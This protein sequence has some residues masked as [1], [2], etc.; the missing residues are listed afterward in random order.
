MSNHLVNETSPYLLQHADNPVEWY[1]WGEEAFSK[2]RAEDKPIFLSIGYSACHWCHVMAH[3]SF[4]DTETA[5][6]LN[7]SFIS[8]KVDREERPDIDNVYMAAC[9]A[10]TGSGGWPLT[11]FLTPEKKPF[12]AGTYFPKTAQ[13]G[14]LGFRELLNAINEAWMHDREHLI[15]SAEALTN[16]FSEKHE[17]V[18]GADNLV[19]R[20]LSALLKSFD[21]TCGGFGRAPKFPMPQHLLFLLQQ[22]EKNNDAYALYAATFTLER[23]YAGGMFDH[24][25]GGFCR[26]STDRRFLVPHFEKMLYD[27]ALLI[28]VY[29]K[30]FE[31]TGDSLF[32]D[33]AERTADY[34]LS[35]M[36]S[37]NGGFFSA[38]DADSEGEEGRFYVFTPEEIVSVL[39]KEAGAAFNAC[40]DITA[41]GNF[42]GRN[43]PNCLKN[44][45]ETE[46][47]DAEKNA[48]RLYR[49]KRA[50]LLT[51][52]KILTFWNTLAIAAFCALYRTSGKA[53]H[54]RTALSTDAFLETNAVWG[55]ELYASIKDGK[56]GSRAF[57]DDRA[58]MALAKLALYD[59][60]LDRAYL[61][62]AVQHARIAVSEYFDADSGGFFFSGT[63]NEELLFRFKDAADNA[64]PGGNAIMSYVF[65]RLAV[66]TPDALPREVVEKQF[67]YMKTQASLQPMAHTA[68]LIALSDREQ[69]PAQI[70]AVGTETQNEIPLSVP[71]GA[72]VVLSDGTDAAYPLLN[73]K[74]TFYICRRFSCLPP[75]NEL[76][77]ECFKQR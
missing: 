49:K 42:A 59:A 67:A 2:A 37:E 18:S 69:P 29:C 66:L 76:K 14:M 9:Q 33:I 32:A 25:G 75:T 26:Y 60:T 55:E 15:R 53:D 44:P 5:Q 74:P 57:L 13:Y 58:G 27:N 61:D 23:M 3:E 47:F 34:L 8:I 1:P 24:I 36:R 71:L 40:F 50:R 16:A 10:M 31:L 30:A 48:L 63:K 70:V 22:Y 77:R 17:A 72:N 52:E 6:I 11:L 12:Y 21:R 54:L 19:E 39:G 28:L 73:E 45:R 7:R 20:G 68:F 56:K 4:E 62:A 43:I 51:D 46:R 35:E 65:S 64:M 41:E 38:Q